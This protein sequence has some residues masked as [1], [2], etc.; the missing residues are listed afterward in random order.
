MKK[1][2]LVIIALLAAT[3]SLEGCKPNTSKAA[4]ASTDTLTSNDNKAVSDNLLATDSIEYDQAMC[5]IKVDYP[6]AGQDS[7]ANAVRQY[8]NKE[9]EGLYLP[10]MNGEENVTPVIYK[11]ELND[12]KKLIDFYGKANSDNLTGIQKELAELNSAH[13]A[14]LTYEINI[15]KTEETSTYITYQSLT[16]NYM[17]GAHG[18]AFNHSVNIS[19]ATG[20]PVAAVIDTLKV[21]ELQ[22][23]LKKGVL[24][25][26]NASNPDEKVT[27]E[28]LADYLFIDNGTIPVPAFTPYL[29]KEGVCFIY[30]QYEIGPYALGMVTFTVPYA[31]VKPFLTPEASKLLTEE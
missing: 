29:T 7:L 30:Q 3:C 28:Q 8:I 21:K 12:G 1:V 27:E 2:H 24:S 9:L 26:L 17:G 31:E 23:L 13:Q 11:G 14:H 18:S 6:T 25:Y 20:K 16:Y 15:R 5:H 19:K 4:E 10:T 22:P